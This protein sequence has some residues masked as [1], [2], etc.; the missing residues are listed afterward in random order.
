M[1]KPADKD[2][3]GMYF[4]NSAVEKLQRLFG[5]SPTTRQRPTDEMSKFNLNTTR[6]CPC[7]ACESRRICISTCSRFERWVERGSPSPLALRRRAAR[8]AA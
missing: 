5:P 8:R 6:G 1:K 7:D 3:G 4:T 2:W